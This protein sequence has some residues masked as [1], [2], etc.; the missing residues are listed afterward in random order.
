M[1]LASVTFNPKIA[2]YSLVA[3]AV[4]SYGA[5]NKYEYKTPRHHSVSIEENDGKL[6]LRVGAI[7]IQNIRPNTADAIHRGEARQ[8]AVTSL[9]RYLKVDSQ[10]TLN[11]SG[12]ILISF[13]KEADNYVAVFSVPKSGLNVS[14][15]SQGD[16][17]GSRHSLSSVREAAVSPSA[18]GVST[19]VTQ[20]G[21]PVAV[22]DGVSKILPKL[23]G[24]MS[25]IRAEWSSRAISLMNEMRFSWAKSLS[26]SS[27]EKTL[28][29]Y[30][31]D[32]D[33]LVEFISK[34]IEND[35]RVTILDKPRLASEI[36][37]L[38]EPFKA[39]L[40]EIEV[41]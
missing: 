24:R 20:N 25:D 16:F 9:A 4:V 38:S 13:S 7:A 27:Y 10:S 22:S 1:Q 18:P 28:I 26:F 21:I 35:P 12:L 31:L 23:P 41:Q 30:S 15:E 37:K 19:T 34:E 2:V 5:D 17:S 14:V 32:L 40:V 11:L 8:F 3:S 29:D 39:A 6:V 36:R 33:S